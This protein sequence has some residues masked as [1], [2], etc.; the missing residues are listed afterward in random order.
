[1]I[2]AVISGSEACGGVMGKRLLK[3]LRPL[4]LYDGN[5]TLILKSL[6]VVGGDL[7]IQALNEITVVRSILSKVVDNRGNAQAAMSLPQLTTPRSVSELRLLQVLRLMT[8]L[9]SHKQPSSAVT[10][11][12]AAASVGAVT[13]LSG[14]VL[15]AARSSGSIG[16][17]TSAS[18]TVEGTYAMQYLQPSL[19]LNLM[20]SR[21]IVMLKY[22]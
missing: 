16:I 19:S 17:N 4:A 14:S 18:D 21:W 10:L 13:N 2:L 6:S 15:S 22:Y 5:W 7:A 11:A 20:L 3:I 8:V 9:R 12:A 1:M